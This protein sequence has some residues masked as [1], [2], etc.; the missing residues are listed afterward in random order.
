[1]PAV[2]TSHG[3]KIINLWTISRYPFCLQELINEAIQSFR[4]KNSGKVS[5]IFYVKI[6]TPIRELKQHLDPS[7]L[8]FEYLQS[9]VGN[10]L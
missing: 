3:S 10:L 4:Q 2:V 5:S 8:L 1:M 9:V 7:F 6:R